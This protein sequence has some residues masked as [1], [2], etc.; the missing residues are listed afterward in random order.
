[1]KEDNTPTVTARHREPSTKQRLRRQIG[2]KKHEDALYAKAKQQL[3]DSLEV[4]VAKDSKEAQDENRE[5]GILSRP[6][7]K[8]S[9]FKK[10]Q[11]N[12]TWLPTHPWYAKRAHMTPSR[13][14]LWNF[15]IPLSPTEKSYRLTH[16]ASSLRGCVAWDTS[17]MSTVSI[18]GEE[19]SILALFRALGLS[20]ALLTLE[21]GRKWRQGSRSWSGWIKTLTENREWI[22]E[23]LI[24]WNSHSS[25]SKAR[26]SFLRLHPSAFHQTWTL[27]LTLAKLQSPGLKITDLRYEIGSL[28]LTGP[29]AM[30]A[31]VAILDPIPSI[32]NGEESIVSSGEL[33][34]K[35]T[36]VT[37]CYSLPKG[38]LMPFSMSDPRLRNPYEASRKPKVDL[39]SEDLASLLSDWPLD[40][41]PECAEL[42]HRDLRHSAAKR[43]LTQKAI[44]RRK[45]ETPFGKGADPLST[46][47]KIPVL[48]LAQNHHDNGSPQSS[49]FLLLPWDTIL[50]IWYP[51]M[52]YPLSCGGSPRFGGLE[53]TRQMSFESGR[54]WFP[55]DYPGTRAGWQWELTERA[56]RKAEWERKPKSKRIEWRSLDLGKGRVGE[57]GRGW[58]CDWERLFGVS[59]GQDLMDVD[60]SD[61]TALK[62]SRETAQ[63]LPARHLPRPV[64]GFSPDHEALTPVFL[65][66]LHRGMPAACSRIYRLPTEDQALRDL[67]TALIVPITSSSPSNDRSLRRMPAQKR[68]ADEND[69]DRAADRPDGLSRGALAAS[70][71]NNPLHPRQTQ[72][73]ADSPQYPVVPDEVDLIGFVTTGA[74]N[75]SA[76]KGTAIGNIVLAKM[77]Q[78]RGRV[79]SSESGKLDISLTKGYCIIREAGNAVGRI[80][81]WETVEM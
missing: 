58:A 27:L 7:P 14:P 33:F 40:E 10:R 12:K 81:R 75:L 21:S 34:F 49:W 46:D 6:E 73:Q 36:S 45:G 76:G 22:A 37:D 39:S 64:P 26:Q 20:E 79:E 48:L 65:T 72:T 74:F 63:A 59:N 35:L 52:Y 32:V 25:V 53:Q 56:K 57:V 70:L 54:P 43:M 60:V 17:Y 55:A 18:E 19:S 51:L 80:A 15:A 5:A 31:L 71:L 77:T 16:R 62:S 66:L 68:P 24:V 38:A 11:I 28:Q 29:S 9:K 78:P 67:W 2:L 8:T 47:P 3:K 23:V 50:S 42:F 1:M 69:Q 4:T 41:V 13:E 30:E 61:E 44:N